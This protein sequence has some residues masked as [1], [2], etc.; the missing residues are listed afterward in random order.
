MSMTKPRR[1]VKRRTY[2][3]PLRSDQARG[4]SRAIIDAAM[5]LFGE[6][7]YAAVSVDAIAEEAGVS[8][9]TVFTSVG[10]KPALLKAAYRSAFGRAA[11]AIDTEMP[12]VERP[13]T[14]AL[15]AEKTL[16]KYLEGYTAFA[17]DLDR[18]VARVHVALKEAAA[19]DD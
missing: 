10:G 2:S 6:R 8:R 16:R 19:A 11:G 4:T 13:R 18:Y 5:K 15:R 7:G 3:S 12:V 9:A 14:K 1:P 17:T